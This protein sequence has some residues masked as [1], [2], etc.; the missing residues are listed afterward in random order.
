MFA[1]LTTAVARKHEQEQHTDSAGNTIAPVYLLVSDE[2][3][4]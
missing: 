4:D 1:F 3:L 2:R